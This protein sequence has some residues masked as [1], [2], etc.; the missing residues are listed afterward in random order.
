MTINEASK[1][2][3]IP[4]EILKEYERWGLCGAVKKV[5]GAWQ[6][7]DTDLERLS[8]IMSLHDMGFDIGEIET[9]MKL[10]LEQEDTEEQRLKMLNQKRSCT[11][12][13]IHLR[14]RQL[15][16]LDYLRYHIRKKQ[17]EKA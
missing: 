5:M 6:Y 15:Q 16:R 1:R 9:Y 7:D 4:L 8:L 13:E 14:E 3:Q 12:D 11:L 10:L 17:Q 2:Y